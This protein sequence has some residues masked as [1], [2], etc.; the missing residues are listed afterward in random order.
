MDL[1]RLFWNNMSKISAPYRTFF[2]LLLFCFIVSSLT[3]QTQEQKELEAKR[4]RLQDEIKQINSLLSQKRKEKTNIL[5]DLED[6]DQKI[7]VRKQLIKL[8][9]R[10][11]NLIVKQ[12]NDNT[13]KVSTLRNDLKALKE[14]YAEMIRKS[15]KNRSSQSRLM[16]LLSSEDFFQ[17]YKR[18]QYIKQYTNYRKEQGIEIQNKTQELQSLNLNLIEQ[19]E[20]K[21]VLIAE[22]KQAQKD[23]EV[24]LV[25][26]QQLITSIKAKETEYTAQIKKKQRETDAIDQQIEKLITAAIAKSNK[27]TGNTKSTNFTLTAEAKIVDASF[28]ANKGN[29]PW[30]V[31]KG[32]VVLGYGTQPHPVVR[33]VNIQSNGVRIATEEGARA[34]SIF[35]GKVIAVQIIKGS[36]KAVLVQHGNYISVYNNLGK[37]FVKEGD[38][39]A[40]KQELGEIFTSKS[41]NETLLKFMIYENSKTDNPANWIYQM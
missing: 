8:T 15:Y 7:R 10:Q 14:D 12:I 6:L 20:S 31:E 1:K 23:L 19:Q 25:M 38:N 17:A 28:K 30:P 11:A 34:R 13:K 2:C 24:E 21:K 22:N 5:S 3:A 26:Q 29:L 9:N 35:D 4:E 36:N 37:V 18:L 16:F 39:V 32:L 33:S 40:I 41:T 27:S